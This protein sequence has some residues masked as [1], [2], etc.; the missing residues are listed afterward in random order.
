VTKS[1]A[2]VVAIACVANRS[3]TY[4]NEWQGIPIIAGISV[5]SNQ[6]KQED[7]EVAELIKKGLLSTD[8]KK[9][10]EELKKAMQ[11]K[12]LVKGYFHWSLMDNFEWDKGFWPRFGLIEIDYKTLERKI[13][14]SG[15]EYAKI[16]ATNKF[17]I[18]S[19]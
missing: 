6:Y 1:G 17:K 12:I 5:P 7:E 18:N 19:Q 14:A 16:C 2:E 10:W 4:I 13:R 15:K 3:K 11:E 9:D 8:P